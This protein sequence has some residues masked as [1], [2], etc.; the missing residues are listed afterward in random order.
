MVDV[1][2]FIASRFS[3]RPERDAHL[4]LGV[5]FGGEA[6]FNKA[7]KYPCYFRHVVGI[8]P[9]LNLRWQDCHGHYRG[10]FDPCCWG[11]RTDYVHRG[12]V[13]A[14][15]YGL[16]IRMRMFLDPLYSRRNPET[17]PAIIRNNPIEM[18]DIYDVQPGQFEMYVGYGGKD[19]FNIGAQ[20]ESFL[21]VA[22][23]RGLE[24]T[25]H[26]DPNGKHNRSTATRMI[27][28]I[29]D[30]IA[31]RLAPFAPDGPSPVIVPAP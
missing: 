1:W 13:L 17:L 25:V 4:I 29:I 6:A 2:N 16:P 5:S 21:F 19:Q 28:D 20:I 27:P 26:Y 14:R 9:P 31:P 15:F 23:Q 30:W 10:R 18:L 7:I 12:T 3:I 8:F 22:R 11:W 24:V